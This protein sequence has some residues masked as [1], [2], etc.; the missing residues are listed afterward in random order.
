MHLST[1]QTDECSARHRRELPATFEPLFE[2]RQKLLHCL[3][4]AWQLL[5]SDLFWRAT[6][7][8]WGSG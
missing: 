3:K 1:T 6:I 7:L 8:R 2:R 4:L 5:L